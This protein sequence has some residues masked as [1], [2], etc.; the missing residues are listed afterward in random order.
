[1]KK[2]YGERDYSTVF[3]KLIDKRSSG[4]GG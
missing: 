4:Y 2:E 3:F 1:M